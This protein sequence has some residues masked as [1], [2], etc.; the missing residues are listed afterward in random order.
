MVRVAFMTNKVA[1]GMDVVQVNLFDSTSNP[2][3]KDSSLTRHL[4]KFTLGNA[5][6][7]IFI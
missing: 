2:K 5:K 7:D 1:L 3:V 6:P 4:E